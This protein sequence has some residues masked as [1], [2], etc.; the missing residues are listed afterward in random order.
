MGQLRGDILPAD[1]I[2]DAVN[3][4]VQDAL[5]G[6]AGLTPFQTYTAGSSGVQTGKVVYFDGS[7]VNH[8][9]ANNVAHAGKVVGIASE[10]AGPGAQVRVQCYS[11]LELSEGFTFGV[12][13]GSLFLGNNGVIVAA[14]PVDSAFIQSVALALSTTKI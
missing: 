2:V 5:E 7:V 10:P 13:S 4:G 12:T 8:A 9:S 6:Q 11:T 1:V 14:P 3:R